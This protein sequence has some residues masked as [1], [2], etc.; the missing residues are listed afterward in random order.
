[1]IRNKRVFRKKRRRLKPQVKAIMGVLALLLVG[2]AVFKAVSINKKNKVA[3]VALQSSSSSAVSSSEAPSSAAESSA[4]AKKDNTGKDESAPVNAGTFF[5]DACFMG[6]SLTVDF[7]NYKEIGKAHVVGAIGVSSYR[8]LNDHKV[9]INEKK[10]DIGYMPERVAAVKPKKIYM[11]F[12]VNDLCWGDQMTEKKFIGYY[13]GLLDLLKKDCP[14]AKI[15]VQSI[16]PITAA[17]ENQKKTPFTNKKVDQFNSALKKL[18]AEKG[19]KYLDVASIVRGSDGKLPAGV[20]DDG[21][22][23]KYGKYKLWLKYL[24]ENS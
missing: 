20:S 16:M 9:A 2:F 12:G 1:M 4:P 24:M 5:D 18:S 3:A 6:D 22:H 21:I 13:G 10:S 15:Y 23:L 19:C 7:N 8:A 11:M 17:M 14:Q